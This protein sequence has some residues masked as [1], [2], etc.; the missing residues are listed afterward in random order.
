M[1]QLPETKPLTDNFEAVGFET[2]WLIYNLGSIT[3]ISLGLVLLMLLTS[4]VKS[5]CKK[6]QVII[7][8]TRKLRR[9]LYWSFIIKFTA[10]SYVALTLSCL[11]QLLHLRFSFFKEMINSVL[12]IT[13]QVFLVFFPLYIVIHIFANFDRTS[14]YT[15]R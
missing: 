4:I 5:T 7:R 14:L 11:L 15:F 3:P 9:K 6:S 2:L 13:I 10:E 8:F 1:W 12:A